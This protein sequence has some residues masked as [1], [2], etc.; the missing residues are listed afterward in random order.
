MH[1]TSSRS[2]GQGPSRAIRRSRPDRAVIR[3][4]PFKMPLSLPTRTGMAGWQKPTVLIVD[5]HELFRDGLVTVL[6]Q[7]GFEII[8]AVHSALDALDQAARRRPGVVLMDLHLQGMS[9]VEGLRRLTAAEPPFPVVVLTVAADG[10]RV[11]E[12][13]EAGACGYLLKDAPVTQIVDAIMAAARGESFLAPRI[14]ARLVARLREPP[15]AQVGP[16]PAQFSDRQLEIL[17]LMA[18]GVSNHQIAS[19]LFLSEHTVKTHIS[20]ILL[21]LEAE[22]RIQAAV[23]A[24][25]SRIV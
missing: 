1:Y 19:A 3:A 4:V 25:R 18:R 24:V 15:D 14:A 2:K 17:E 12:A 6:S 16:A 20:S 21:K 10:Q 8:G 11:I 7:A 5:D 13:L 23:R 9:G 22:N